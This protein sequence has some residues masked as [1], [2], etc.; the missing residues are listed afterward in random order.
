M[1]TAQKTFHLHCSSL[2]PETVSRCASAVLITK[3]GP[4]H[5]HTYDDYFAAKAQQYLEFS[6]C[7]I[8][9]SFILAFFFIFIFMFSFVFASILFFIFML[10]WTLKGSLFFLF[11]FMFSFPSLSFLYV[12]THIEQLKY[13]LVT[14]LL[15]QTLFDCAVSDAA[16]AICHICNGRHV[17][18]LLV[19]L[20]RLPL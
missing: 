20:R 15:T 2:S 5:S 12:S 4:A 3:Y 10:L 6:I 16:N 7:S 1:K 18:R 8:I 17:S 9:F 14:Q 19:I 13:D 11:M